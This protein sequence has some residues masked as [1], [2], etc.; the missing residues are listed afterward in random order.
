MENSVR[1]SS[2]IFESAFLYNHGDENY[3]G[4]NVYIL[5]DSLPN[6]ETIRTGQE[7]IFFIS[8]HSSQSTLMELC[9]I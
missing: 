3:V 5:L 9:N 1:L 6:T 7:T 4:G 8:K 2:R